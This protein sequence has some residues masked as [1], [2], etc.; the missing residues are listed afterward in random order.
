MVD[1]TVGPFAKG[2]HGVGQ[3]GLPECTEVCKFS[4]CV[5]HLNE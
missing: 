5:T 3:D 1:N 4:I 2:L